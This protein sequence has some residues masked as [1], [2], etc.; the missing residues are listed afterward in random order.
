MGTI[1]KMTS[2]FIE[3][4]SYPPHLSRS[5]MSSSSSSSSLPQKTL[6]QFPMANVRAPAPMSFHPNE[7]HHE[8]GSVLP[9][10]VGVPVIKVGGK[11][12]VTM[13]N[14]EAAMSNGSKKKGSKKQKKGGK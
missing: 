8:R 4:N 2:Y 10:S 5:T 9:S 6:L 14:L 13:A 1:E 3:T 7:Q 12:F 11:K